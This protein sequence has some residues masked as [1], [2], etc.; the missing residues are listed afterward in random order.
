VPAF[1]VRYRDLFFASVQSGVGFNLIRAGPFTAG[2]I[3]RPDFGR[4]AE[5]GRRDLGGLG[6]IGFAPELGGFAELGLGRSIII[7]TEGRQAIG[8][9][10]GFVADFSA[11]YA[12][13]VFGRSFLAL[14]PRLRVTD[15]RYQRSYFA[16]T[17]DEA[18]ATGL[19]VFRPGRGLASAGFSGA[20]V[21][22]LTRRFDL[23]VAGG[24]D[25]LLD[26]PARSPVVR[27]PG[28][29]RDQPSFALSLTYSFTG[30][31]RP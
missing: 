26:E 23:A 6:R 18:A 24:Y 30:R 4:R 10:E 9:H 22:P 5:D 28:G 21:T 8:G 16:V 2:P 13:P 3:G 29:S 25:R 7:R 20:L 1:D 31:A 11:N 15:A 17:S 12:R 14:G 19:S 27:R